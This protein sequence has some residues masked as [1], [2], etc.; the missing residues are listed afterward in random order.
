[1]RLFQLLKLLENVDKNMVVCF[2]DEPSATEVP[3]EVESVIA[4]GVE[5]YLTLNGDM[6]S[7]RVI[8]LGR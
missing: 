8:L 5:E 7:N 1:M 4:G 2:Y 3:V 6:E